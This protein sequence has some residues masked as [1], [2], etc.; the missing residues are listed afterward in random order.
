MNWTAYAV[1]LSLMVI[2]GLMGWFISL[3]RRNVT[4][5]DSLWSLFFVLGCW[6]YLPDISAVVSQPKTALV[7]TL[8]LIWALRLSGYLTWRNGSKAE[9]HRYAAIRANNPPFWIRSLYIVFLLQAT[10]AW[11][12]SIPLFY[13][14]QN[15]AGLNMLDAVALMLWLLGFGFE[16]LG[17]WQ[18]AR[19]KSRP[20]SKGK[21]MRS[22]VWAYTR[23]P[24]YFGEAC[25]WW[26]YYL[27]ACSAGGWWTFPGP[28][29][30]NWLLLRVSGVAMLEK[31]IGARRPEYAEYI[32]TT[33]AFV[34]FVRR[35]IHASPTK[36]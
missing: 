8:V 1:G 7:M 5:V 10:L 15:P 36:G 11:L 4:I 30:M 33:P 28:L 22:G 34:P 23:H 27:F 25:I 9:D 2:L 18:L 16:A 26:A 12:V 24:N 6:A 13:I 3:Y 29:M 35:V 14:A 20:D 17:D 31:D 21:V 32:R 19:F